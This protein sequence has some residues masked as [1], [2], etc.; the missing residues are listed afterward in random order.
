MKKLVL[1]GVTFAALAVGPALA[2]DLPR[3]APAYTPPPPPPP[4]VLTWTGWYI[5]LNAGAVWGCGDASKTLSPGQVDPGFPH[6]DATQTNAHLA[7]ISAAGSFDFNNG[8]R[9][10]NFI[11]GGQIGYNWQFTNWVVGLEADFQGVGGNNNNGGF[12]NTVNVGIPGQGNWIGTGTFERDHTWLATFRGR[13]G[14]LATPAF[15]IY[16]T[17]G[18]ARGKVSGDLTVDLRNDALCCGHIPAVGTFTS[19]DSTRLGWTVGGGVEWMFAPSWS[20][21]GEYLYYDLGSRDSNFPITIHDT[22]STLNA[23]F[24]SASRIDLKGSIARVGINWHFAPISWGKSPR[25][26]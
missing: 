18:L 7:A 16:A 6:G 9:D 23:T 12:V 22:Q 19:I 14:F 26:Y 15:L 8:C 21:K 10:A 20:V 17:G 1:T 11:G 4:P 2:A 5:G 3:K 25:V 24:N 13:V